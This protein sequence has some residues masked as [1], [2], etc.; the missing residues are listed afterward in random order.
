MAYLDS[1]S[2]VIIMDAVLTD[3][4]RKKLAAG[5]LNVN[6]FALFDD[7][8]DYRLYQTNALYGNN[9]ATI[10]AMPLLESIPSEL[11][12]YFLSDREPR[13]A[14]AITS[15]GQIIDPSIQTIVS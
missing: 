15:V 13:Q 12:Q 3:Y 11:P 14:V 2:N 7:E 4:G 9:D 6:R 10:V 5:T 8:V 1:A